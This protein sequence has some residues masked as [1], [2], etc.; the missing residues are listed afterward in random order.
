MQAQILTAIVHIFNQ[1]KIIFNGIDVQC[2]NDFMI[3]KSILNVEFIIVCSDN[4][5]AAAAAFAVAAAEITIAIARAKERESQ[6]STDKQ[7]Y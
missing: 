3:H 2:F 1:I 4:I 7:R 5:D 6:N